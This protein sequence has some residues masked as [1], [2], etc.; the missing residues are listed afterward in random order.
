MKQEIKIECKTE[1]A[2]KWSF[3]VN[4]EFIAH[5]PD[6]VGFHIRYHMKKNIPNE[7]VR[8]ICERTKNGG[9]YYLRKGGWSI[10]NNSNQVEG[11]E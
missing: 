10:H 4:D 5:Y 1:V 6:E 11:F 3:Y 9:V 7:L 2:R 8:E